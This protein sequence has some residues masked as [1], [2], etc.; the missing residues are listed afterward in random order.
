MPSDSKPRAASTPARKAG[1]PISKSAIERLFLKYLDLPMRAKLRETM[2]VEQVANRLHRLMED[3]ADIMRIDE[4]IAQ[5]DK[6]DVK[7]LVSLFDIKRK[8][9]ERMAKEEA[10]P[11]GA[12]GAT[13]SAD[14][15]L[16]GGLDE[17][18]KRVF[19]RR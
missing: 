4:L 16:E 6:N 17:C 8:M 12:K 1:R 7:A 15:D 13:A 9:R 18:R 3:F 10:P 2:M 14:E 11:S 19:G 5:T